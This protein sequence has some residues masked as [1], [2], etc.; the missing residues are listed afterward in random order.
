VA[1]TSNEVKL[2][3]SAQDKASAKLRALR[4]S[5]DNLGNRFQRLGATALNA[6][7]HLGMLGV[8][9]GAAF[10][11]A[12]V[13]G[14]ADFEKRL[15]ETVALT[16]VT[17]DEIAGISDKLLKMAPAVA[18]GPQELADAFYFAASAMGD[19][20][21]ALSVVEAS[22]KAAAS[23]LGETKVVVDALSS[24]MNAY[25]MSA[26]QASRVTDILIST[27]KAG[28]MPPEDLAKSLGKVVPLAAQLGVSFEEV[29]ASIATM[30]R[31]GLDAESS[32]TALRGILVALI[33]PGTQAKE[34]LEDL[35][36]S[37]GELSEAS[38]KA[39]KALGTVG[40]SAEKL[41]QQVKTRGLSAVLIDIMD[42][43]EG[44]DE[45]LADLIPNV[46]ALTGVLATAG[47]QAET[48]QQVLH[49]IQTE[50]GITD[51]A[52]AEA[53]DTFS[54]K[55]MQLKASFNVLRIELG[56]KLLPVLK[57]VADWLVLRQPDIE[58]LAGKLRDELS[59]QFR[60]LGRWIQTEAVPALQEFGDWV[61]PKLQASLEYPGPAL[62]TIA[63][64]FKEIVG[65]AEGFGAWVKN[66]GIEV[67]VGITAMLAV[68]NVGVATSPVAL[69]LVGLGA[70]SLYLGLF[71][72]RVDEMPEPMLKWRKGFLEFR[73]QVGLAELA[74]QD[75]L[76][77]I[78]A[79]PVGKLLG[80]IIPGTGPLFDEATGAMNELVKAAVGIPDELDDIEE[81]LAEVNKQLGIFDAQD[82]VQEL[83]DLRR[84]G[85]KVP[86]A[87][88]TMAD[89]GIASMVTL[90]QMTTA[91]IRGDIDKLIS[92]ADIAAN[93]A[94][95]MAD[96]W[97]QALRDSTA[98][99]A[100]IARHVDE[101]S[102]KLQSLP[103]NP[104]ARTPTGVPS[105]T[106]SIPGIGIYDKGGIV[107]GPL[108]KPQLAVV[109]G[110][111]EI[112]PALSANRS[113]ILNS[114]NTVQMHMTVNGTTDEGV[115]KFTRA[116][117]EALRRAGFGGSSV[118]AGAFIPA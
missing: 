58:R 75:F 18:K 47:S 51:E 8:A 113:Q 17:K 100:E 83:D 80:F 22:A 56:N 66:H 52:F 103:W 44:N 6:A 43:F 41:R 12:A 71:N 40:L 93:A 32:S 104:P 5:V 89:S 99:F 102:Q 38:D 110:R 57:K 92:G 87:F 95:K 14:A 118:S 105:T 90:N 106:R 108:G 9:A 114:Y 94:H 111:E 97:E 49:D 27:V 10:G 45:A 70:L 48:Y 7:K 86:Q 28:K 63:S 26:D 96:A 76:F 82:A 16:T 24:V 37:E 54:F 74:V 30:T 39:R 64:G 21:K 98:T 42:A 91:P 25:Q 11:V 65:A 2:I 73:K 79:A 46:R 84:A 61:G 59:P 53:S 4:G 77:S 19:T 50:V 109:H 20:S 23:G 112:I 67:A 13:K 101:Q 34:T 107:P 116:F 88:A 60:E 117:N 69:A 115:E 1:G 68:L 81:E 35:G 72:Q 31:V 3:I 85:D 78:T 29:G 62:A 36:M 33:K 15:S 55:M